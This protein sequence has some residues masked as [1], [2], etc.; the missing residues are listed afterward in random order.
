M[1]KLTLLFTLILST[2]LFAD[3]E[4]VKT[5]FINQ[6]NYENSSME[7]IKK[8]LLHKAKIDAATEI[9]GD[10]VK[11]NVVIENGKLLKDEITSEKNGIVHIKGEPK[12]ANG[13]NFG[14][15]QVTITAYATDEELD[16]MKPHTILLKEFVYS[17]PDMPLKDLKRA[18]E[19]AFLVE[20]IAHKK[21]SIKKSRNKNALARAYSTAIN[22]KKLNFDDKSVSYVISGEVD[23]IPYFL[24]IK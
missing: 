11:E 22:I 15:I 21:P 4:V 9:Y 10:F 1:K 12:Y 16:S 7:Q 13:K 8:I 6:G 17:N 19:D 2:S 3:K 23:Y 18:A 14:D 20:A 5:T 24:S